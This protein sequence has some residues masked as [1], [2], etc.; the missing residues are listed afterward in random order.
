M[1]KVLFLLT[2]ALV[3]SCI[4]ITSPIYYNLQETL[5]LYETYLYPALVKR[6]RSLPSQIQNLKSMAWMQI[7]GV[8]LL[9]LI[10][11]AFMVDYIID[12]GYDDDER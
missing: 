9:H 2:L 10:V 4:C 7:T 12:T 8:V 6:D 11:W 5:K 3:T 1:K